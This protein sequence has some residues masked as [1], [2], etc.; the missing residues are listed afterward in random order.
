VRIVNEVQGLAS[1]VG[2]H[3]SRVARE[4]LTRRFRLQ[5]STCKNY[6]RFA[7]LNYK[8]NENR[9]TMRIVVIWRLLVLYGQQ[10][11]KR[12][13]AE[14]FSLLLPIYPRKRKKGKTLLPSWCFKVCCKHSNVPLKFFHPLPRIYCALA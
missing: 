9:K 2:K 11:W 4:N 6:F 3:L 7:N 14:S 12:H 8:C 10:T 1:M 13:H 5:M